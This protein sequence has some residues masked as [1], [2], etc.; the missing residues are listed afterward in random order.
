ML[1]DNRP[2]LIG[3]TGGIGCG[4]SSVCDLIANDFS[5]ISADQIAKSFL[6]EPDVREILVQRWGS[7]VYEGDMPDYARIARIVFNNRQELEFLNSLIHPMVLS[8]FQIIVDTSKEEVLFFEIPLLFEAGLRDCFDFVVSVYCRPEIQLKR[9]AERNKASY[10]E[11]LIRIE[12]QMSQD[13]RL[14]LSDHLI[15]NSGNYES[16]KNSVDLLVQLIANI[17]QRRILPFKTDLSD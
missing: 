3:I 6:K 5:V 4:K 16:L 17:P 9:L 12:A 10:D 13:A 11:M 7:E 8:R 2:L 1:P 15:D 14:L